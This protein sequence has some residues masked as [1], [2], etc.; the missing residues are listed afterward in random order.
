MKC[1]KVI[2]QS[3]TE[4]NECSWQS[5][6][7]NTYMDGTVGVIGEKLYQ[8]IGSNVKIIFIFAQKNLVIIGTSERHVLKVWIEF[9]SFNM[10]L[11]A[12]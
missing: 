11:K 5:D 2:E 1:K 4:I 9:L 7:K 10:I 12:E 6:R 3:L 8:S